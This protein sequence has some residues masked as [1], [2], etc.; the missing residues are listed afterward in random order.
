MTESNV[1]PTF[2]IVAFR[3]DE[4]N[5]IF[6][7]NIPNPKAIADYVEHALLD[8]DADVISIRRVYEKRP[9]Q[10]GKNPLKYPNGTLK[11]TMPP[12]EFTRYVKCRQNG[13][14]SPLDKN[15]KIITGLVLTSL[16]EGTECIGEY[17]L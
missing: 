12:L 2:T 11:P 13:T 3:Y 17:D 16:P 15:N 1:T 9:E 8:L 5:S 10:E 6:Y 4:K 14:Y 7:K